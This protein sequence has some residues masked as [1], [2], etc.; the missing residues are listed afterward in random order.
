M[1]IEGT[2]LSGIANMLLEEASRRELDDSELARAADIDPA[3]LKGRDAR[4]M[5]RQEMELWQ[6]LERALGSEELGLDL[7]QEISP[8]PFGVVGYLAM[9]SPNL[10]RGLEVTTEFH[11]VLKDVVSSRVLRGPERLTLTTEAVTGAPRSYTDFH[12]GVNVVLPLRW[13]G[14]NGVPL[15]VG[16]G[17]SKP[18]DSRR[19]EQ[20]FRCPVVFDQPFNF[21]EFDAER[22]EMPMQHSQPEL[23]EYFTSMAHEH[24][25]KRPPSVFRRSLSEA[26]QA[27][28]NAG[29]PRV[30]EVAR[31]LGMS[32]RTL[33]RRL[34]EHGL[35]FQQMLD[36]TRNSEALHLLHGT[37]LSI[38]EISARLG[39]ADTKSFRRAFRRWTG[40]APS[41]A[42]AAPRAN[43]SDRRAILRTRPGQGLPRRQVLPALEHLRGG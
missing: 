21:V 37:E 7:L 39:Y 23:A 14:E 26:L 2:V 20:L 38:S 41:S 5:W 1:P 3:A 11:S 33:Q 16:L 6:A 27:A 24:Q 8:A 31:R 18:N 19:Y 15:R 22:A 29:D 17:I 13:A 36:E 32:A 43:I 30:S 40:A 4:V 9:T 35:N 34:T 42:R 28:L 12:I 10:R 25:R